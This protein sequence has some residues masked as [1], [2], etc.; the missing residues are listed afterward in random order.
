[1]L[2]LSLSEASGLGSTSGFIIFR[3]RPQSQAEKSARPIP[4]C[5]IDSFFWRIDGK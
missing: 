3:D 4:A 5:A 2:A 1:M